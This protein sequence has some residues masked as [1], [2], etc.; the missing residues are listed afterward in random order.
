MA[1]CLL[2]SKFSLCWVQ[3][4]SLCTRIRD[5]TTTNPEETCVCASIARWD[6]WWCRGDARI[7]EPSQSRKRNFGV[8]LFWLY[9]VRTLCSFHC[10]CP[11]FLSFK[12]HKIYQ[13][14][15]NHTYTSKKYQT[16]IKFDWISPRIS[17][18]STSLFKRSFMSI[19]CVDLDLEV[20]RALTCPKKCGRWH[21][22]LNESP[23]NDMC[24]IYYFQMDGLWSKSIPKNE[25]L[26][27]KTI[28]Y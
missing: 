25:R 6:W 14:S 8:F 3:W 9:F 22:D 23:K 19:G 13:I 10:L 28:H 16:L 18:R 7:S 15:L 1:T 26:R 17:V 24:R 2:V 20:S 21:T 11:F 4:I 27:F 5:W 12:C